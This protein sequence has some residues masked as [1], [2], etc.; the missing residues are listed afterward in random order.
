MKS[1]GLELGRDIHPSVVDYSDVQ[2]GAAGSTVNRE[3]KNIKKEDQKQRRKAY[4]HS[5]PA[6]KEGMKAVGVSSAA[7]GGIA[8][9]M[10]VARKRKEKKIFQFTAQDWK[11]IGADTGKGTLRGGIRDGSVYVLT[12]FTATPANVA[13]AYV[14]AAF[15]IASQIKALEE[16]TVS[17]EDFVINCETVCLDVTVSAIA[18]VAGQVLIPVPVLGAVIGNAAGEFMYELCRKYG[19][20]Q[21]QQ[22]M[23]NY[24]HE[25]AQLNQQL[26]IQYCQA[27]LEIQK[28]LQRFKDMEQLAFSEDVNL[29]FKSSAALAAE[30]G[31]PENKIL[32][33]VSQIDDFFLG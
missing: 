8:F 6:L 30:A 9:C 12:N 16:G 22:I 11:E 7:E 17:E 20:K 33:N 24:N 26:D 19:E 18:S 21:S 15:G 31:V 25:M 1:K 27:V 14:T 5:K 3:E 32:K 10:S 28:A 29:A 23:I 4:D 2:Q 13:S